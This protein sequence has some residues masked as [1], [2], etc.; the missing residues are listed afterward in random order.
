MPIWSLRSDDFKIIENWVLEQIEEM[1]CFI[2]QS[3]DPNQCM[4]MVATF[5]QDFC[6]SNRLHQLLDSFIKLSCHGLVNFM[7]SVGH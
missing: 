6:H 5:G 7:A 3:V 2:I 1:L 4:L